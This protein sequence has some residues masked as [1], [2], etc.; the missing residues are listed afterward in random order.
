MISHKFT[1]SLTPSEELSLIPVNQH[2]PPWS[3][4]CAS[5]V[6]H[7]TAWPPSVLTHGP[8]HLK[9]RLPPKLLQGRFHIQSICNTD[10]AWDF[11]RD[12]SRAR[13]SDSF[14]ILSFLQTSFVEGTSYTSLPWFLTISNRILPPTSC[15]SGRQFAVNSIVSLQAMPVAVQVCSSKAAPWVPGSSFSKRYG[16]S[17]IHTWVIRQ[18]T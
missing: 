12:V 5:T 11:A 9:A 17:R 1:P 18:I 7:L 13:N 10:L 3:P 2:S 4:P 15:H 14:R 16:R 8:A 6:I